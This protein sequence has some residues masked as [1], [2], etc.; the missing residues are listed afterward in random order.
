[1]IDNLEDSESDEDDLDL[2]N[3]S[4]YSDTELESKLES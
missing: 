4:E 1:M 3:L 2:D